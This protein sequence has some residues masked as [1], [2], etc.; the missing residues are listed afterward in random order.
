MTGY[1]ELPRERSPQAPNHETFDDLPRIATEINE[2]IAK[3]SR[4]VIVTHARAD[5]D[6]VGSTLGMSDFCRLSGRPPAGLAT[7]DRTIPENLRFLPG[8]ERLSATEPEILDEADLLIFV[9]CADIA[10]VGDSFNEAISRAPDRMPIINIDHHVTNTRFGTS[11]LVIPAAAATCEIVAL[12]F[13]AV[14]ASI[15]ETTAT[16]LLAGVYGD[17]LGLKT[18][19]TTPHSMRVSAMLLERGAEL[20]RI[21]DQLFR[22]KPYSTLKLWAEALQ[23]VAWR[24]KLIWSYVDQPMLARTGADAS[25]AE[26]FVNFIA[27]AIG[28]DAAALLYETENAWRVSL[29]SISPTVDVSEIAQ[30]F[31]GGGHPKAAGCTLDGGD[32]AREAFLDRVAAELEFLASTDAASTRH[33]QLSVRAD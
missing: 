20:D 15:D 8:V 17:T 12:L 32:R 27:G 21:V 1:L 18:Q 3:A 4:A 16:Y 7:G 6:A 29:R 2:R 22:L 33:D 14:G 9:D 31:G 23:R 30:L 5:A 28:A 11:N 24:G 13:E 25:E 19:S 26:G 10:R